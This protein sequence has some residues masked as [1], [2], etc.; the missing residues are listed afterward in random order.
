M[1]NFKFVNDN[2]EYRILATF[3]HNKKL[4]IIYTHNDNTINISILKNGKMNKINNEQEFEFVKNV[5]YELLLDKH[6]SENFIETNNINY[7]GIDYKTM[8]DT[9]ERKRYFYYFLNGDYKEAYGSHLKELNKMFNAELDILCEG[10]SINTKYN[11]MK[12]KLVKV[13]K[14]SIIVLLLV[15]T[16]PKDVVFANPQTRNIKIQQE[17]INNT[18]IEMCMNTNSN[19]FKDILDELLGNTK[20]DNLLKILDDNYH[21]SNKDKEFIKEM[22]YF[23][24]ENE[25]YIDHETAKYNLETLKI[26][27]EKNKQYKYNLDSSVDGCYRKED[28]E[29]IIFTSGRLENDIKTK[30][31]LFHELIHA[32]SN[33]SFKMEN[34][35][36]T[37]GI[38][39]IQSAEYMKTYSNNYIEE[40]TYARILCELIGPEKV[41]EAFFK[42]NLDII[43]NELTKICGNEE[44]AKKYLILMNDKTITNDKNL[45]EQI[46]NYTQYFYENKYDTNLEND[47]LMNMYVDAIKTNGKTNVIN[48]Y[49]YSKLVKKDNEIKVEKYYENKSPEVFTY[50]MN[51]EIGIKR[52]LI[53][54]NNLEFNELP[55]LISEA[56]T[57]RKL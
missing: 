3:K 44:T 4:Y 40:Q 41:K 20:T 51:H 13:G 15:L 43:T 6:Y 9:V 14:T 36:L 10:K 2:K 19:F 33:G 52:T 45:D 1:L 29:I 42:G 24:K 25:Q 31:V 30:K 57:I 17:L 21:I 5:Y 56:D 27:Y 54:K 32:V 8:Y 47:E 7:K 28:N 39:E 38:T 53:K 50:Q 26:K 34:L 35:A 11:E 46:A 16:L 37:E 12:R 23:F 48:H 55:K 49:F 18:K 22:E